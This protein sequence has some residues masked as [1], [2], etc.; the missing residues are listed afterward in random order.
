MTRE[1][2]FGIA[3]MERQTVVVNGQGSGH[4]DRNQ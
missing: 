1:A 4:D 3:V 2:T